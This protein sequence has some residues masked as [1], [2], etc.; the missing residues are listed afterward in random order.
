[1]TLLQRVPLFPLNT[2]LFPRMTLP[3]RIFEERYKLMIGRCV[4][5]ELPFGVV[6]IRSGV[7]VGGPAQP[8]EVGTLARIV[9]AHRNADGGFQI[10][11][12]GLQRFR[13][14]A[15][16]DDEAYLTADIE[17]LQYDRPAPGPEEDALRDLAQSVAVLYA[18]QLRLTLALSGMW[19]A[20]LEAPDEPE[21]LADLVAAR[22]TAPEIV[23][24]RM[25]EAPT[26]MDRLELELATLTEIIPILTERVRQAQLVRWGSLSAVN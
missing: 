4:E 23:K 10:Q 2:V 26:L 14:V 3:L 6:L 17:M 13:I 8:H 15:L 5:Q 21:K 7:E 20:S 12:I 1:M 18:E 24:Q 11:T 9:H 25:L 22:I 19:Q 16:Q